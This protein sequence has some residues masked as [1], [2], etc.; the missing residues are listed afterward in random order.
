VGADALSRPWPRLTV[1]IGQHKTGSKALQSFLAHNRAAL[2]ARGVLYPGGDAPP[3]GVR[4]YAISQFR[5]YALLRREATAEGF[6]E[7]AGAAYWADQGRHCSPF[8]SARSFFEAVDADART[9]GLGHVVVSSEDLFDMHTAHELAFAPGLVDRAAGR[10][11]ALASDF[12]YDAQVVAYLRRQDHLL[13]AHYVQYIK[14]NTD[15][16][17]D[18]GAFAREF[19]PRLDTR[20][21]L[22]RWAA[23]FGRDRVRVRRYEPAALPGGVVPDFFEGVLGFPV[24]ADCTPPPADAESVNRT[25]DRD[26]VEFIRVLNRRGA[27]GQAVFARDAVLDAALRADP[28]TLG[29]AG[30]SAWLSPAARRELLLAHEEGNAAVAR[31]SL[32]RDD[33]R[34]FAEPWPADADGW[35]PYPGFTPDRATAIAL[36][37]H[38]AVLVHRLTRADHDP[39]ETGSTHVAEPTKTAAIAPS[40]PSPPGPRSTP[41][42]LARKVREFLARLGRSRVNL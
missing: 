39:P 20:S 17:L 16:E 42:K 23:A 5:L 37:V 24:P 3:S 36:A 35:E 26:Y 18:F 25:L 2:R 29:P 31:D 12:G 14:G 8:D 7:A 33:G 38:D 13:G 34:L 28:S 19:A 40:E 22:A 4:A 11:A 6:G 27:A 1:H 32:G 21:L 9:A 10:L 15:R 30:V 41:A